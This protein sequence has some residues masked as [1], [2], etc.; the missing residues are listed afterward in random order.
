MKRKGLASIILGIAGAALILLYKSTAQP[1]HNLIG[2]KTITA[3][4]I[5]AVLVIIGIVLSLKRR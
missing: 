3:L 5:C 4:I 2:P 1:P